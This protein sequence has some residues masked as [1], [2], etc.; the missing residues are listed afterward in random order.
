M[1]DLFEIICHIVA[2]YNF[3]TET[4]SP[5]LLVH[6]QPPSQGLITR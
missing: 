5:I 1:G 6:S 3:T 2:N 4:V